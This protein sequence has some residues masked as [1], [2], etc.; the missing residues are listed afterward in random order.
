M[1]KILK[2]L[3]ENRVVPLIYYKELVSIFQDRNHKWT[4]KYKDLY[5]DFI[6]LLDSSI[7]CPYLE[8]GTVPDVLSEN[9]CLSFSKEEWDFLYTLEPKRFSS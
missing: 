2:A 6:W 9:T 5:L 8:K 3:I 4:Q 1:D 7:I